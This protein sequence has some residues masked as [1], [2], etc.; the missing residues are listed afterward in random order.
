MVKHMTLFKT[1]F[2]TGCDEITE[3]MLPWF[4]ENYSKH[5]NT[6]LIFANFG[7]SKDCLKAIQSF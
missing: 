6:P 4:L 5:N 7:V 1:A 3:W 2:L